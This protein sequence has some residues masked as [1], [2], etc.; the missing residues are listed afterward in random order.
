MGLYVLE[1]LGQEA[2]SPRVSRQYL[3][4][5][6]ACLPLLLDEVSCAVIFQ[7][8]P[9]DVSARAPARITSL[10]VQDFLAFS[11]QGRPESIPLQP[12]ARTLFGLA[13]AGSLPERV[14]LLLAGVSPGQQGATLSPEG[15]Q[16]A[17]AAVRRIAC[18]LEDWDLCASQTTARVYAVPWL[19][20]AF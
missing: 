3:A 4:D 1:A 20:T 18:Q 2:L 5:D 6:Y 13:L 14:L 17:R 12:L 15:R 11:S 16:T 19:K 8:L 7:W 9:E 10:S